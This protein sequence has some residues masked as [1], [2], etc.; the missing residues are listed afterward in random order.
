M[1]VL[2]TVF[3]KKQVSNCGCSE[4]ESSATFD[5]TLRGDEGHPCISIYK[6]LRSTPIDRGSLS[7]SGK[8]HPRW[9]Y[10]CRKW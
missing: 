7:G 9:S 2:K 1:E 4:G 8:I 6:T 10:T 3:G 5:S